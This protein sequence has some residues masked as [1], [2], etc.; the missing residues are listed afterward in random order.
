MQRARHA[1]TP[2]LLQKTGTWLNGEQRTTRRDAP[3]P[4]DDV[5]SLPTEGSIARI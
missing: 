3:P 5:D 4:F 2:L 1:F